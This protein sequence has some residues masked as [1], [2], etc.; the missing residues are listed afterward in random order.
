MQIFGNQSHQQNFTPIKT[1]N[2]PSESSRKKV[3]GTNFSLDKFE[4]K[5]K[6]GIKFGP[7]EYKRINEIKN[8]DIYNG[9]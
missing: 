2:R 6:K 9:N 1:I 4:N 7:L 3:T 8:F 5:T